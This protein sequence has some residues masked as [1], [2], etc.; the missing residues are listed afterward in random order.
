MILGIGFAIGKV[1]ISMLAA[2][3]IVYFASAS[4]CRCSGSSS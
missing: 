2:Y 3:A 1:V 4:V